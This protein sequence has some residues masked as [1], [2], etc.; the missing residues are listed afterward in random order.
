MTTFLENQ[1]WAYPRPQSQAAKPRCPLSCEAPAPEGQGVAEAFEHLFLLA[2]FIGEKAEARQATQWE[3]A[4]PEPTQSP[5]PQV[6]P[7]PPCHPHQEL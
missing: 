7:L 6:A 4:G 3:V 2:H 5:L 1:G